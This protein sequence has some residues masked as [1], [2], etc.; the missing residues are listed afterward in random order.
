MKLS[1]LALDYDGTV[2]DYGKLDPEVA[3]AIGEAR[4]RGVAVLLVTGRILDELESLLPEADLFDAIVA[5]NGAVLRVGDARLPTLL[6]EPAPPAFLAELERRGVEFRAGA[7]VVEAA[8]ET[9]PAVLAAIRS[10]ELPLAIVFNR[11]R[12]MVLPQ[13]ISKATGLREALRVLRLS[14]HNTAAIGDAEN[15]YE[16][17]ACCE[18]GA[19]VEWGSSALRASADEVVPG[20][21]PAD[22]SGYIRRLLR[23]Q[24]LPPL[25]NSRRN[26]RVGVRA[27]GRPLDLA[28]RGRNLLVAGDP[29]SGKS[30]VM[31]LLCEQLILQRYCVCVL[32]PEGDYG[33]LEALPGVIVIPAAHGTAQLIDVE[34]LLRYPD[35]SVVID[36]ARIPQ[37]AKPAHVRSLLEMLNALR[38]RSGL[39]HRIVVDE[40]HYFLHDPDSLELLDLELNSYALATYRVS[41]LA[42]AVLAAADAIVV[43]RESDPAEA[44]ALHARCGRDF[45][46]REWAAT[47]ASLSLEEAVLLPGGE[48]SHRSLLR[49]QIGERLT[50][51]VRH[52]RKYLSVPV[53]ESRSFVFTREG[54]PTGRRARTMAEFVKGLAELPEDAFLAHL[55]RGDFRRWLA[56]VFADHE[57]VAEV[58]RLEEARRAGARE[59]LP[60]A[61]ADAIRERYA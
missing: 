26:L 29:Q 12:L 4:E 14:M 22:V 25:R 5:E 3:A 23:S 8:A 34:R 47:L 42:P 51:H 32:D 15:D 36:L 38:R 20:R 55:E 18:L 37:P 44:A 13:S 9:A 53:P 56:V 19:A 27:D 1:V 60:G 54:R 58:A 35:V 57:L 48:E 11:G 16:L 43:T 30:W 17:L 61:L 49:F 39:P 21:G 45:D 2:A 41:N 46:P 10:S 6:G 50:P 31:G 40:A 59:G 24:R 7:C 52:R 33:S 28:V